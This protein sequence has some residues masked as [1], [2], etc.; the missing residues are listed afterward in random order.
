MRL[1]LTILALLVSL[2][3]GA[4]VAAV[5]V[6]VC[7]TVK[8]LRELIKTHL[9]RKK[10]SKVAFGSTRKIVD[11]H[12]EELLAKAPSMADLEK[13]TDDVPYFIVN[14]DPKTD[15]VSD[16]T[17]IKAETV[18]DEVDKIFYENDGIVLFD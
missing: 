18:E 1:W 5:I 13:L 11:K 6:L 14:Y 10:K 17:A 9:E 8:K 16:V 4:A 3:A 12:A 7:L 15:E 2:A